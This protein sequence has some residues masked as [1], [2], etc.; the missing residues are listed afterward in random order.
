MANEKRK[1]SATG[2]STFLD[3]PKRYYWRYIMGL[4]PITLS[5][6][7]YDHDRI[8][9]T[10][11]ASF[12]DR[13][14]KGTTEEGNIQA[15]FAEWH[16]QTDWCPEKPKEKLTK[17]LEAL[18]SK[19]YENFSPDD[20][21]RHPDKSELWLENDRFCGKL[22]GLSEE[23]II[24]E[25]KSTSRAQSV[26]E[27]LWK[28]QNSLQVRLYAV[29]AKAQGSCIEFAYKD[30]PHGL[31]RGPVVMYEP[32]QI[33]L[34]EQEFNKI[35]DDIDSRGDDPYNYLCNPD[36]CCI[37]SKYTT[38]MCAYQLLCEQGITDDTSIFYRTRE[39]R[40]K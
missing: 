17:A 40:K 25:V 6:S 7:S 27:Q 20:G 21:C 29:L 32:D 26:N 39:E 15:T 12:V 13:F 38:S 2:I 23:G 37:V 24:H 34:W 30:P 18:T 28:V 3:S 16:D 14:Y 22:D 5:V 35:A 10:I 33:A 9:G 8:F 4:A 36:G 1:L 19:Y 31:F 11:W